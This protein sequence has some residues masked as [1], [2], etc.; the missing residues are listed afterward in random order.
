MHCYPDAPRYIV[1]A[2]SAELS[3]AGC[4]PTEPVGFASKDAVNRWLTPP[5]V[6]VSPSGLH[7]YAWRLRLEMRTKYCTGANAVTSDKLFGSDFV[8]TSG[9]EPVDANDSWR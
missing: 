1:D 2:P 3:L 9:L 4:V 6:H 5:A 8:A 7:A